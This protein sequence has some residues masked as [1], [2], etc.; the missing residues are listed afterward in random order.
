MKRKPT[1]VPTLGGFFDILAIPL[2]FASGFV[3]GL[4]APLAAIAAVVAGVR[5]LTGKVPYLGHVWEDEESGRH[6]SFKL[7]SP[8]EVRDLFE[9]Q[10]EEIGGDILRMQAEIQAIVEETKAEAQAAVEEAG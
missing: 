5:L 4:A 6:L 7:A 2:N 3:L 10:K 1:S 9:V 8:D